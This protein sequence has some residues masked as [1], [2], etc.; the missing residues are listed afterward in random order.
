MVLGRE[1]GRLELLAP[2]LVSVPLPPLLPLPCSEAPL[3]LPQLLLYHVATAVLSVGSV[4][5]VAHMVVMAPF[6]FDHTVLQKHVHAVGSVLEA[7]LHDV[8]APVSTLHV[9]P[10]AGRVPRPCVRSWAEAVEVKRR[11]VAI[12]NSFIV[13]QAGVADL[14]G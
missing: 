4:Q 10:H 12:C 14:R 6:E 13:G 1:E 8:C 3:S 5:E 7:P 9:C 2:P 11:A